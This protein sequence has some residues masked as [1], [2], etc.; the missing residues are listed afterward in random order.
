MRFFVFLSALALS[1]SASAA[2]FT[3]EDLVAMIRDRQVTSIEGLL[4]LLPEDL[5]KDYVLMHTSESLQSATFESPR[6]ILFGRDARLTCAFNGGGDTL[7]CFQF[8]RAERRFD[9]HQIVFPT[10]SNHRREVAFSPTNRSADGRVSCTSC[11]GAD[12]RPNWNDYP[13][14]PGAYGEDDNAPPERYEA[15]RKEAGKH[16][17][18]RWL[19]PLANTF[20]T[21]ARTNLKFSDFVGRMNAWRAARL[22]ES[23][24]SRTQALGFAVAALECPLTAV[25]KAKVKAA[26]LD[27]DALFA[28]LGLSIHDW[29]TRTFGHDQPHFGNHRAFEH[30]SGFTFELAGVGMAEIQELADAGNEA[31]REGLQKMLARV[32]VQRGGDAPF[33]ERLNEILPDPDRFGA[34]E[35]NTGYLCPELT[36]VF[37]R[38]YAQ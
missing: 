29:T 38:S 25:Q 34:Y 13:D 37:V 14:W 9:F 24:V 8:R 11:H 1:I 19:I 17:R 18:Y 3:Y 5:R 36:A 15:Y 28:K 7:E 12:P 4:P 35:E 6:A 30:Q 23:K 26:D 32:P 20:A 21:E 27:L 2:A 16:P 22:L 33:F 10:P 31:L